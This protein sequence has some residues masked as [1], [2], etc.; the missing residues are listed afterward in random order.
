[1]PSPKDLFQRATQSPALTSAFLF[2]ASSTVHDACL[3]RIFATTSPHTY[4]AALITP[5]L[6]LGATALVSF[7]GP[8]LSS[9]SPAFHKIFGTLDQTGPRSSHGVNWDSRK[10]FLAVAF[11]L[12]LSQSLW[13]L[14]SDVV[15]FHLLESLPVCPKAP[16]D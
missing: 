2:L 10:P 8:Q 16:A 7:A 5:A 12:A 6:G 13:A 14:A 1:M 11:L 15:P 9:R 4:K 3:S